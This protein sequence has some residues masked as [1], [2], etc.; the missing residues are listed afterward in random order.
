MSTSSM[1]K[2]RRTSARFAVSGATLAVL[3]L[4]ASSARAQADE[5]NPWYIGAGQAFTHDTNV[6]RAQ[7][8]TSDTISSTSLLGGLD[9]PLGRG[10]LTAD[11][12][13]SI[14]RFQDQ[15]QLNNDSYN[16]RGKLDW[17]TIERVSGNILAYSRQ[18]LNRY[19]L[20]AP[21]G[22]SFKDDVRN[23]GIGATAQI[24][25]PTRW[26]FDGGAAF[27]TTHHSADEEQNR[28]LRQ[29]S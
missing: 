3:A 5:P 2:E 27:D 14:N 17:A 1:K 22:I 28:N 6:L 23:S 16:A 24:G 19:D 8:G 13:Y 11:L 18:S 15:D 25:G 7:H 26:T 21:Q 20:S 4:A 12:N 10:R 9:Q 29:G